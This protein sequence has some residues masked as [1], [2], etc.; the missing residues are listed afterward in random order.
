LTTLTGLG[1]TDAVD[2]AELGEA[3]DEL[4]WLWWDANEPATGWQLRLAIEDPTDGLAWAIT[5]H[6]QATT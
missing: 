2:P 6:D 5:A 4:R 3:A 1:E